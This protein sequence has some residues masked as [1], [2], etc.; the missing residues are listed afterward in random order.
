MKLTQIDLTSF[1]SF[2][3]MGLSLAAN[4]VLIGGLNGTGKTSIRDAIAW[5]LL[6]RGTR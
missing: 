1:R 2:Q 3:G 6:G 4:R 5:T